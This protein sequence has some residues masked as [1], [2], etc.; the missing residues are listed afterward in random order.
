ML[1]TSRSDQ[2]GELLMAQGARAA[3]PAGQLITSLGRTAALVAVLTL[4]VVRPGATEMPHD[5]AAGA[6]I[7][8][9]QFA[10]EPARVEIPVGG[11]VAWQ[12]RDLAAH[13]ATGTEFDTGR[14]AV[15]ETVVVQ[16]DVPGEFFYTCL[17]HANMSGR[18]VVFE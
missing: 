16:F 5:P 17:Y 6:M 13:T 15:G 12:N 8:I 18:V 7:E 4:G 9:R 3:R 10:Y 11:R 1:K 14:L 2:L